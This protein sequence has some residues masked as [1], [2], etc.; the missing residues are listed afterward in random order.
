MHPLSCFRLPNSGVVPFA[1]SFNADCS[2]RMHR[3]TRALFSSSAPV[4]QSTPTLQPP[5]PAS[6]TG[7]LSVYAVSDLHC[8]YPANVAFVEGLPNHK[9]QQTAG[10]RSHQQISCCIVAGDVSDDLRVVRCAVETKQLLKPVQLHAQQTHVHN[11]LVGFQPMH[12]SV[13]WILAA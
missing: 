13:Q 3:A 5:L 9:Q 11:Y 2:F 10:A 8:D 12:K 1:I 6:I 7:Q 4:A